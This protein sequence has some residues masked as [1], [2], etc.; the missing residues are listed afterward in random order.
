MLVHAPSVADDSAFAR[1]WLCLEHRE[2]QGEL[3][4]VLDHREFLVD[5]FAEHHFLDYA[6][7][8]DLEFLG[9]LGN[10]FVDKWRSHEVSAN[11]VVLGLMDVE[12]KA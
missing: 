2:H 5:P 1:Q 7:F 4:D 6:L 3:G 12:Q 9:L 11:D 10:L 8:Y